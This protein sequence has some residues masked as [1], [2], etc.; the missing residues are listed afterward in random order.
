LLQALASTVILG[1][2]PRG[3]HDHILL[4]DG[5]GSLL[6]D[7]TMCTTCIYLYTTLKNR[8]VRVNARKLVAMVTCNSVPSQVSEA[9]SQ[10]YFSDIMETV[11]VARM[12]IYLHDFLG[13]LTASNCGRRLQRSWTFSSPSL[14]RLS[15]SEVM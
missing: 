12:V 1:S 9:L 13:S 6:K 2:E 14:E 7:V 4:S 8:F 11:E 10:K 3:T 5:S 15:I